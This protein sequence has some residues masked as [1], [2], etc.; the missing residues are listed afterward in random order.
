MAL[1]DQCNEPADTLRAVR[2]CA[3]PKEAMELDEMVARDPKG[4][5]SA[6]AIMITL[7]VRNSITQLLT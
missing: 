5:D 4:T 7:T 1:E 2:A 3:K 6:L